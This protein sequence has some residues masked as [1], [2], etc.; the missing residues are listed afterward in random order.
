MFRSSRIARVAAVAAL[1]VSSLTIVVAAPAS[2]ASTISLADNGAGGVTVTYTVDPDMVAVELWPAGSTCASGSGALYVLT[3]P[4]GPPGSELPSS[5]ATLAFGT[6]IWEISGSGP[7]SVLAVTTIPAGTFTL[8]AK[9]TGPNPSVEQQLEFTFVDG[10]PTTTTTTTTA[11][12]EP[13][14]PSFTG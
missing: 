10:E 4:G 9:I 12:P 1:A 6:P 13:S 8:C 2:A 7:V 3:N 5:P 11:S 14:T